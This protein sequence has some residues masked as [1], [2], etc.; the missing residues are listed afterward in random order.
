MRDAAREDPLQ[1]LRVVLAEVVLAFDRSTEG[2]IKRRVL[3]L[4]EEVVRGH[5]LN[6]PSDKRGRAEHVHRKLARY[7]VSEAE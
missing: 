6:W 1:V 4:V 7:S 2:E 3:L 5:D